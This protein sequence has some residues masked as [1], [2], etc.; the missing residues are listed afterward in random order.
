MTQ[1]VKKSQGIQS[2]EVGMDI[3][4]RIAQAGKPLSISEL[5][6]LCETSKSKLHRYLV[7]FIKTGMLEKSVDAKY[8]LGAEMIRLGL[9]ASHK[10]KIT[11]MAAPHLLHIKET[12]NETA[13]LAIWGENGPFFIS[14][15]QSNHPV[16]IGVK[17]GTEISLTTSAAGKIFSTYLPKEITEKLIEKEFQKY[18]VNSEQFWSSLG[19]VKENQ[20]SF[21]VGTFLPGISAI[22]API[23]NSTNNL[24]AALTVV[25]LENTL[26]TEANSEE[27]RLLKEKAMMISELLGWQN[28]FER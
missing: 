3:L 2:I 26:K 16:N 12:L 7:S 13:A 8:T 5:A 19:F 10:S 17:V 11:E 22:A 21:V 27:V 25:G 1:D 9:K 20:Y 28:G 6:V 15:E 23:F 18:D 24:V 14:W 4:K